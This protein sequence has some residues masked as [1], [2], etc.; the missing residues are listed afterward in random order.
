M[1]LR[2]GNVF[3]LH[4]GNVFRLHGGNVLRLHSD[5]AFRL[6]GGNVFRL[7][8]GNGLRAKI[9]DTE[10]VSYF[11]PNMK[12]KS[13]LAPPLARPLP[14]ESYRRFLLVPWH[15]QG[16]ITPLI[17]LKIHCL[18]WSGLWSRNSNFRLKLQVSKIGAPAPAPTSVN[19]WLRLRNDLTH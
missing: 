11:A 1:R 3:R 2:S 15:A 14:Q 12:S 19:F 17:F 16:V 6:H 7:H 8:S 10:F 5:N 13:V 4:S 9:F 18:L